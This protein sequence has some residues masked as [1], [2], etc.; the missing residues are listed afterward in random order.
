M[1]DWELWKNQV[2]SRFDEM[3][4]SNL[5]KT[6]C[7]SK[8]QYTVNHYSVS[9]N[10]QWGI[11]A[12]E[13]LVLESAGDGSST[14]WSRCSGYPGFP[15][16]MN[17]TA[18]ERCREGLHCSYSLSGDSY[19]VI[20]VLIFAS[21]KLRRAPLGWKETVLSI[22][23]TAGSLLLNPRPQWSWWMSWLIRIWVTICEIF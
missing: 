11:I 7:D 5:S 18:Q 6:E 3:G 15:D 8:D 14:T 17:S 19:F 23:V 22:G 12:A 21:R 4:P 10:K 2:V 16:G 9:A 20:T 1:L 13:W